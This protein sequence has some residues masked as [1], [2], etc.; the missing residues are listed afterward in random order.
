MARA[1]KLFYCYGEGL[2]GAVTR[3]SSALE[4]G[5]ATARSV[6]LVRYWR[7]PTQ[8]RLKQ[9]RDVVERGHGG[10]HLTIERELFGELKLESVSSFATGVRAIS[11]RV[12]G[13]GCERALFS[14][15]RLPASVRRSCAAAFILAPIAVVA[16]AAA[17]GGA[18]PAVPVAAAGGRRDGVAVLGGVGAVF[19]HS[20][21]ARG[22]AAP[23]TARQAAAGRAP[24]SL[25]LGPDAALGAP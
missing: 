6:A 25:R 5:A 18:V 4:R 12:S 24:G 19:A 2:P 17:A 10:L 9:L 21:P 13:D 7:A 8:G 14:G 1:T 22:P 16:G 23:A 11:M 15:L 20:R 3:E